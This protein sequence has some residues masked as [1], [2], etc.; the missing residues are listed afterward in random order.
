MTSTEQ[1]IRY[2]R[3]SNEVHNRDRRAATVLVVGAGPVGLTL[4]CEL[5]WRGVGVRIIDAQAEP[6]RHSKAIGVFPRTLELLENQGVSDEMVQRGVALDGIMVHAEGRRIAKI[7]AKRINS[8]YNFILTLEQSETERILIN[9]L[10]Q[11][12]VTV[13]R[14]VELTV[15]ENGNAGVEVVLKV[16]DALYERFAIAWVVGCDGAHSFVRKAINLPFDGERYPEAFNL[17]D[18]VMSG[19]PT[20]AQQYILLFLTERGPLFMAPLASKHH[21]QLI[22]DEPVGSAA[23]KQDAPTLADIRQWWRERVDYLPAQNVEILRAE[24]LSR[25]TIHRRMVPHLRD[26]RVLLAGDAAHIHSPAGAQGMNGGIQDA[27]NLGWKLALVVQ[28][29][30]GEALLNTYEEER[31]PITHTILRATHLFTKMA[32]LHRK[33]LRLVR[34]RTMGILLHTSLQRQL[35]N[36]TAGLKVHYRRSSLVY[37]AQEDVV[38]RMVAQFRRQRTLR[39]G[40]RAPDV[41]FGQDRHRLY[42]LLRHPEHTLLI[43]TGAQP[44]ANTL[45]Q[46]DMLATRLTREYGTM[47]QSHIIT[48][49]QPSHTITN[50]AISTLW[51]ANRNVHQAYGMQKAGICLVR[52][53]R[54]VACR[55][56]TLDDASVCSAFEHVFAYI[57]DTVI[58]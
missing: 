41:V 42:D 2:Q 16:H 58:P 17:A 27:I 39:P 15:L 34:N 38:T 24:W 48:V 4:A 49:Q 53:D 8:H 47:I 37:T 9:R 31:L 10:A 40:E 13:E 5:A 35:V 29:R 19:E 55:T 54:Y 50:S 51:D 45:G 23:I 44:T 26:R 1:D 33:E 30:A 32:T 21:Y 3:V 46:A 43:F 56:E 12:G 28:G 11:L 22:T 25:F 36:V 6:S 20:E 7:D 57:K 18:V 52:P 14:P